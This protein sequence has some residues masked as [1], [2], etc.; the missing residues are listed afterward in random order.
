MDFLRG[1][2]GDTPGSGQ[3]KHLQ[4]AARRF[5]IEVLNPDEALREIETWPTV[6]T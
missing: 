6:A 2:P 1:V 5:G 4:V 3:F